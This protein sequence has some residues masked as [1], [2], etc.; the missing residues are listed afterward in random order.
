MTREEAVKQL[1]AKGEP[2]EL[3]EIQALGRPV[4]AFANGPTSLRDLFEQ[5]RSALPFIVYEDERLSFEDV[6]R[7]TARLASVMVRGYGIAK[8]DRVAI[9]MRNYPEW[10]IAFNA[11]TSI[12]AIAVAMN[13]LWRPHELEFALNDSGP[14]LLLADPE[15]LDRLASCTVPADLKVIVVRSSSDLQGAANHFADVMASSSAETMPG[16]D[17]GPDDD[18]IIVYTSGSIGNPKG[19]VSTHR[20]ILSALL[21]WEL[22]AQ[23]RFLTGVAQP[24]APGG[25]QPAALLAI[26][27]FHVSGLHAILL[28]SYRPQRRV[29]CMYKWDPEL[30]VELIEREHIT[31]FSGPAAVTGDLVQIAR[32]LGRSLASLTVVGGGGAPRAP[33]QVRAIDKAFPNAVPT[34]GWGMTET[35]SVGTGISG[36]DYL[37]HPESSGRASAILEVRVVDEE[38]RVLPAL[39]RGELQIRGASIMRGYWDRPQATLD[40]FVDG[41]LRTGDVA[42]LDQDGFVYIVD[43]IKDLVIRGGENIGCGAVEAVLLEHPDI[44]EASVYGVPDERLG[45][46]VGATVYAQATLDQTALRSFLEPRLAA[47]QIPRYLHV[48]AEPLPRLASGKIL[49]RQLRDEAAKRLSGTAAPK[50]AQ[51]D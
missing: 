4:R 12:G 46:E 26:P 15:R 36:A 37:N 10:V 28:S 41:W 50:G 44:L 6:W 25:P 19:A 49:K 11:A 16:A 1:T 13:A 14:K 17:L 31:G 21:S 9:S 20:N 51:V 32:R 47:F 24:P 48:S 22:D 29:V 8:G 42:Y 43:R 38:G 45:E 7:R 35:N 27:L 34:T 23:V 18:A 3:V 2:Y 39:S 40:A 5:N 30:A 33:E